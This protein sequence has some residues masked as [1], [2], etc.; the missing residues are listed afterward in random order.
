MESAVEE[1]HSLIQLFAVRLLQGFA[2]VLGG[3]IWSGAASWLIA[4]GGESGATVVLS[5]SGIVPAFVMLLLLGVVAFAFAALVAG[6]YDWIAGLL[7]FALAMGVPAVAGGSMQGLMHAA[8][9]TPEEPLANLYLWLMMEVVLFAGLMML[10]GWGLQKIQSLL[11]PRLTAAGY[12][13]LPSIQRR[14]LQK[15]VN[16]ID[17][18]AGLTALLFGGGLSWLL[19]QTGQTGQVFGGLLLGFGAGTFLALSL[20]PTNNMLPVLLAPFAVALVT[21]LQM[22]VTGGDTPMTLAS[23]YRGEFNGLAL[24]LPIFYASAALAGCLLGGHFAATF[25]EAL[26]GD[27]FSKKAAAVRR[28]GET[29]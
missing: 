14:V 24:A 28:V 27:L 16:M 2:V 21:C 18:L 29:E 4:S 1:N 5:A 6:L 19:L 17:V 12:A 13:P 20:F 7:A 23:W 25:G 15:N 3:W 9:A 10:A 22:V 26:L 11:A 8:T